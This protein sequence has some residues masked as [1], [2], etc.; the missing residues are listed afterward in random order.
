MSRQETTN[1]KA[2]PAWTDAQREAIRDRSG[3]L[4]VTAAAGTGKTAVLTERCVQLVTGTD[5]ADLDRLLVV[6]FTEAAALEMRDRIR[7]RLLE[8]HARRPSARLA[9]QIALLDVAAIST[10]H[11]FCLQVVRE[12]FSTAG[13][14]PDAQVLDEDE[15]ELLKNELL[16][17][18]LEELYARTDERGQRFAAFIADYAGGRDS[19]IRRHILRLHDYLR[20]LPPGE[21]AAWKKKALAAYE[22]E[23]D[24]RLPADLFEQL[25]CALADEIKML[26]EMNQP[27]LQAFREHVGQH[28]GLE[29]AV[30]VHET[31]L[32]LAEKL[33][34]LNDPD[35]LHA[36]I[37][38]ARKLPWPP[39]G[40]W[41]DV[42]QYRRDWTEWLRK[43]W[44]EGVSARWGAPPEAWAFGIR[45][46]R[47]Y[48]ELLLWLADRF[49]EMYAAA[50]R[51]A[52]RI[53][54]SDMEEH[55]Y[56]LLAET[57]G[58][59]SEIAKA[60]QQ[61]FEAVLVD[62][63]QDINP[64]Q[65]EILRLISRESADPPEPNLFVVGDV[66]QS[67][68][69][70]RM[71][72][73]DLFQQ[74]QR[75]IRTGELT[76]RC[77]GLQEN[78][79][80]RPELLTAINEIFKKLM[81]AD[82]TQIEYDRR[83]ELRPGKEYPPADG[84]VV[85]L[86]LLDA[87]PKKGPQPEQEPATGD[88]AESFEKREKEA[89]LIA[90]RIEQLVGT[91]I[92]DDDG[93][94][95]LRYRDIVVLLR[96]T[97]NAA[98]TYAQTLQR[99]GIP[100]Y[101]E[102]RSGYFESRP[103]KDMLSLLEV[104]ENMQQDIPLAAVLRSPVL[105]QALSDADLAE[106][107]LARPDL[108]FHQAVTAYA[109]SGPD[110]ALR[111]RLGKRLETLRCWRQAARTR[112]LAEVI[113][114]IY[115]E[116]GLLE[117]ITMTDD[118]LQGRANLV[119]LYERARQFGT[120]TR[121]GLR[122]FILFAREMIRSGREATAP[123]A[124]SEAEDVVRI[125]SIHASKGL[126]FPVVFLADLANKF[127]DQ[128]SQGPIVMDRDG[129][130]GIEARD[131]QR[132]VKSET[133]IQHLAARSVRKQ[134][135]AEELRVLYVAMTRA[136]ER[137][138]LTGTPKT[139][140]AEWVGRQRQLWQDSCGPLP[141][142]LIRHGSSPLHWL[143]P[144]LAA[145]PA[146]LVDWQEA[147]EPTAPTARTPI[148][149]VVYRGEDHETW[150]IARPAER[151][152]RT[153]I[154]S[155]LDEAAGG[156][157]KMPVEASRA[158][159]R[160]RRLY[161]YERLTQVPAVMAATELKG[162]LDWLNEE[163]APA[164]IAEPVRHTS[165]AAAGLSV[166]RKLR[167]Q[168]PA[169]SARQ[170]GAATHLLLQHLDLS[171]PIDRAALEGQLHEIVARGL[172]S[173]AEAGLIDLDGIVWLLS[174][175]ELGRHLRTHSEA[176]RREVPFVMRLDPHLYA[177]GS[178]SDDPADAA[179][180]R[181]VIDMLW[182]TG[183]GIEIADFKT[184]VVSGREL[185]RRI[186]LYRDQLRIYAEAIRK[187]WQRPVQRAWLA[188]LHARHVEPFVPQPLTPPPA[189]QA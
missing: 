102:L 62:E 34:R 168:S 156:I 100:V 92:L 115:E 55:A 133:L 4:L 140:A 123:T 129:W 76:G 171:G 16:D 113:A 186:N 108:P 147:P 3:S 155:A 110:E 142:Y 188:F 1:R 150:Q 37:E 41:G 144:V 11:A 96:S 139:D 13:I 61:R 111:C 163:E 40:R 126:E 51:R 46:T 130:L 153:E 184:D 70:F 103:I 141:R 2:P 45:A 68:Y 79:R 86:H 161:R 122:R 117:Y 75:R 124:V 5:G 58:G 60:Y 167:A 73:P 148:A 26:L 52:G 84:P 30:T 101:A 67:I 31:L 119:H 159:D 47:D 131:P 152:N 72:E 132:M 107:R 173:D 21:R 90:R 143:V 6:T 174:E 89:L 65:A 109:L 39:L 54:Y 42:P 182:A 165:A 178:G 35:Q 80:S 146:D 74:R 149:V 78:F 28:K 81:R 104:L 49:G 99:C 25:R 18:L 185:E 27:Y 135:R 134:G 38:A 9:R 48:A 187:I 83:A 29:R 154:L 160:L 137:L 116:T 10:L 125:M 22:L 121:Q 8:Q 145:A 85:E 36:A 112:P 57:H 157:D 14:E 183:D 43:K 138:V 169:E 94:R 19:N 15:A 151:P 32:E 189:D 64:I 91:P 20:S 87:G 180:V 69:G 53:D 82:E 105:G 50:K 175:T 95:P 158:I 127:N 170:R 44:E 71:T 181:G 114:R 59:P 23:G 164:E 120:F 176:V 66:K 179:V 17:A 7:Q 24:G 106:I 93:E 172:L 118:G 33:P 12:N 128:D 162:R 98:E 88:D 63:F 56:A 97:R 77:I 136:K 166:P 177:P